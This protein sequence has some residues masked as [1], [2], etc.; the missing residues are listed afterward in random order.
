MKLKDKLK[1]IIDTK[2]KSNTIDV[3]EAYN[4]WEEIKSRYDYIEKIFFISV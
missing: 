3:G 4:L 1:S 2:G